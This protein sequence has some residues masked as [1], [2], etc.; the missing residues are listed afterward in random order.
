MSFQHFIGMYEDQYDFHTYCVRKMTLCAYIQL[1]R[2]EDV[3]RKHKFYYQAAE[4]AIRV[5]SVKC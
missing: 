4:V 5:R 1:L 3:L 2:L